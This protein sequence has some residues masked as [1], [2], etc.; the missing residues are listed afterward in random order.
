MKF[1]SLAIAFQEEK[2]CKDPYY[3]G[4]T[5]EGTKFVLKGEFF[6][7]N[8]TQIGNDREISWGEGG[9]Y[10]SYELAGLL[11]EDCLGKKASHD[12]VYNLNSS[13][14]T[15][16]HTNGVAWLVW[17]EDL[18]KWSNLPRYGIIPRVGFLSK[19]ED[20]VLTIRFPVPGVTFNQV[21]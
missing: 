11:L 4:F 17:V 2:A 3:M 10:A 14:L 6:K 1:K 13:L 15:F 8:L 18:I 19:L 16:P 12:L 20:E 7:P 9:G 5:F 21:G